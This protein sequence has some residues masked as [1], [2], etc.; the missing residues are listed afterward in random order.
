V[1]GGGQARN[2]PR[3]NPE[4]VAVIPAKA[5]MTELKDDYAVSM[6]VSSQ[7]CLKKRMKTAYAR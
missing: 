6:R 4:K 5:G 3:I 2:L 1:T 7:K